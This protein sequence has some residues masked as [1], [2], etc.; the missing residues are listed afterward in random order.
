MSR[1][2]GLTVEE[3]HCQLPSSEQ[4]HMAMAS[5]SIWVARL[6]LA[7]ALV[8]PLAAR[9]HGGHCWAALPA[10]TAV[11]AVVCDA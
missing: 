10:S 5:P 2:P 8:E 11:N 6:H 7:A 3:S 9:K 1:G 4:S